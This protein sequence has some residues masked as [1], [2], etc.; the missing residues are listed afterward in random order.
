M[1]QRN[2]SPDVILNSFPCGLKRKSRPLYDSSPGHSSP[3][4][5]K[6]QLWILQTFTFL[7]RERVSAKLNYCCL[8]FLTAVVCFCLL[9]MRRGT[10]PVRTHLRIRGRYGLVTFSTE[11][12]VW[13]YSCWFCDSADKT[14]CFILY[15]HSESELELLG[16]IILQNCKEIK[17]IYANFQ[18][19]SHK[20]QY[21]RLVCCV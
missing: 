15:L 1:Y 10:V 9:W 11:A 6:Q 4:L 14:W 12:P 20:T 2:R 19:Q 3:Q 8:F 16:K 17:R 21:F 13:F 7:F 5:S 18:L